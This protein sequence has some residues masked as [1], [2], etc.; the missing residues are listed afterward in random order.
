MTERWDCYSP[1]AL[2]LWAAADEVERGNT[3][4]PLSCGQ[5]RAGDFG[6]DVFAFAF[7]LSWQARTALN[8]GD[9]TG[10]VLAFRQLAEFGPAGRPR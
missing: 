3:S 8:H 10:A 1:V 4:A 5:D 9:N 6:E 7:D 2:V